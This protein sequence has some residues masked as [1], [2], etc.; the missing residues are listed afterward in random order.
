MN[1][2]LQVFA[3]AFLVSFSSVS[4]GADPSPADPFLPLEQAGVASDAKEIWAK[5][6]ANDQAI[7]KAF[8][9][10]SKAK[11]IDGKDLGKLYVAVEQ[12]RR[13][14]R[15]L[16]DCG[17]PSSVDFRFREV[18]YG[19]FLSTS[20][21]RFWATPQSAPQRNREIVKLQRD[22]RQ[23]AKRMEKIASM[24]ESD[25]MAA[26]AELDAY[27]DDVF[28]GGGILS[29]KEKDIAYQFLQ[30]TDSQ[31]RMAASRVRQRKAKSEMAQ[32]M[33]AL[34]AAYDQLITDIKQ[35][36]VALGSGGGQWKGQP[37]DGPAILSGAASQWKSVQIGFV[38]LQAIKQMLPGMAG[39]YDTGEAAQR[40]DYGPELA[41]ADG[42]AGQLAEA[43]VLAIKDLIAADAQIGTPPEAAA[44][45]HLYLGL[46]G[47]LRS[48]LLDESLVDHLQQ[49]L[50]DLAARAGLSQVVSSYAAATDDLL[51]WTQR[52]SDAR[53]KALEKKF[54]AIESLSKSK[55]PS[56]DRAPGLYAYRNADVP[57][58]LKSIP[59]AVGEIDSALT[60]QSVSAGYVR[61]LDGRAI[62]ISQ[63]REGFYTRTN[64]P[65]VMPKMQILRLTEDLLIAGEGK[66]LTVNAA[67]AI[68][69]AMKGNYRRVGGTIKGFSAE[70]ALSRYAKLPSIAS[71]LVPVG[72]SLPIPAQGRPHSALA[73]RVE[74]EPAWLQHR[75]FVVMLK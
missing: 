75:H 43:A 26:Q 33:K 54:P 59:A 70:A 5:I 27:H 8:T 32:Q 42:V 47:D 37:A 58:L 36:A 66:P 45:Y 15:E 20:A 74:L 22:A 55:L 71:A 53:A 38:K 68:G 57:V 3:A 73:L 25:P 51:Q 31:V 50:S 49:P 16:E 11:T 14:R 1:R 9:R 63:L 21:T 35:Q 17:E 24:L 40:I 18:Q 65:A 10:L 12:F 61:A 34:R 60:G 6:V 13:H 19:K 67:A 4:V 56:T 52:A 7:R 23:R 2:L 41:I 62:F 69:S 30:P 64:I 72:Y 28:L 44:K 29:P 39:S 46:I 48:R